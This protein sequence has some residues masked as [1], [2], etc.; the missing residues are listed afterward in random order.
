MSSGL[1]GF[2][3]PSFFLVTGVDGLL[4]TDVIVE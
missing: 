4:K 1:L 3:D 2:L